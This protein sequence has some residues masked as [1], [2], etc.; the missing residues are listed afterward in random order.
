MIK[1]LGF[2]LLIS[3]LLTGQALAAGV[4]VVVNAEATIT[5][6]FIMLGDI[7]TVSGEDQDRVKALREL[8]LGSA[9]MP[10]NQTVLT[11]EVINM[12]LAGTGANLSDIT[13]K[14]P[15]NCTIATAGQTVS[16]ERLAEEAVAAV[17]RQLGISEKDNGELTI[18]P[19]ISQQD[20][21][22]PLGT[23]SFKT[24]FPYGV[25]FNTPTTANISIY[26]DGRQYTTISARLSI[27]GYQQVVVAARNIA[28]SEVLTADSLR[29]ERLEVGHLTGYITDIGKVVG[30]VAR[31]SI[32]AGLPINESILSKPI[33]LKRGSGATIVAKSG[34]I[35]VLTSGLVLQDGC[36][37]AI[38]RVKNLSSN[39]IVNAQV[40][41]GSTV[42]VILYSGR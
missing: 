30:L 11:A 33:I 4:T 40:V 31:R 23:V 28:A 34:N 39:K 21:M 1:K 27:K 9:P 24:E 10:G 37:G 16:G 19:A 29:I 8:R 36:E 5:G 13:W 38:I 42:Q 14:L 18:S 32:P 17:K 20:V 2:L 3:W 15:P 26:I 25:R 22:V 7:A 41:D 12:R 35:I 6:P